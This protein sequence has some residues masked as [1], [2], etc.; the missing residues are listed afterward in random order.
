MKN[1]L[2]LLC[3]VVVSVNGQTPTM[4]GM[5]SAAP[6]YMPSRS[7]AS[8]LPTGTEL[9]SLATPLSDI[10]PAPSGSHL[11][12]SEPSS[13]PSDIMDSKATETAPNDPAPSGSSYPSSEPST[14]PSFEPPLS[15]VKEWKIPKFGG[16]DYPSSEPSFLPS[17]KMDDRATEIAPTDPAYFPSSKPSSPPSDIMDDR[18]TEIAPTDPAYF[19][20]S[21]PSS[22]PSDMMDDKATE[23]SPNDPAPSGSSYPSSEPSSEPSLS[24]VKEGNPPKVGDRGN[25]IAGAESGE[26]SASA[27]RY[28]SVFL[29]V[30]P[31]TMAVFL[32]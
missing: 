8:L 4:S 22:P 1:L 23:I 30:L 5:P 26:I 15:P 21:K 11:P 31:A 17:D 14:E 10:D 25:I 29:A 24:P 2:A 18:A 27:Q 13:P 19:P 9:P 7:H 32:I 16:S 3:F 28:A 20:S 12:S 6:S